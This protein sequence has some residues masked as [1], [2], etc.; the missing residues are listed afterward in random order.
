VPVTRLNE[1]DALRGLML[2]LMT[3]T[4]LPTRLSSPLGQPFGYV[5]AAEGFVLLSAYMAGLV[6]GRT[7]REKSI[8]TMSRAFWQRALKVYFCHIAILLFLFTVIAAV[9]LKVD[10]PAVKDLMAY[11]LAEPW[12]AFLA[13]AA[14]L[15]KPPLLDILPMYVLFMLVSPPLMG[16]GLRHGWR[17]VLALSGGL[18]VLA[19]FGLGQWLYDLTLG[20]ADAHLPFNET[21]AFATFAWQILWVVGLWMGATRSEPDAAPFVF[22]A[23]VTAVALVIAALGLGWRHVFGQVPFESGVAANILF[24][25]W[26]LGPLRLV[27][28]LALMVIVIRFGPALL[29]FKPRW[30]FLE[31]LGSASLPV[32]SAHLLMV[33]LVL[34]FWGDSPQARSWWGDCVLLAACFALLSLVAELS[35]WVDRTSVKAVNAAQ[36]AR[37]KRQAHKKRAKERAEEQPSASK[38]D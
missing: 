11:Y 19:Q 3:I 24:D 37:Q 12:R 1:L 33:L 10:Q 6:Y 26:Q 29:G 9:G 18:W 5:S 16:Y 31:K 38:T 32:F 21:G 8:D 30:V 34:A 35:L 28:L 27:N 15:Y 17:G 25:K 20:A 14:L 23:G 36:A 13:G 4:H 22:P 2:V 7:A